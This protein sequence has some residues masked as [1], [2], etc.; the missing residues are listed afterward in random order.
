MGLHDFTWYDVINRNAACFHSR[1]A[2]FEADER[3]TM[4]FAE[5]KRTVDQLACGLQK[6][7]IG[8]GDR[9]GVLGQNSREYFLLYGAAAALGAIVLPINWRLAAEE[10]VFN[11][12][13]CAPAVLFVDPAYQEVIQRAKNKL[14]SVKHYYNLKPRA[15]AFSDFGALID[16]D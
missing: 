4:T 5:F 9:I 10:V 12:N 7:K 16:N 1:P 15:G 14:P 8:K 3:H 11:L 6:R 2:W 13:D